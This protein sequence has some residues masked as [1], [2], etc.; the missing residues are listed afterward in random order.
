MRS[1]GFWDETRGYWGWKRLLLPDP[2]CLL[3]LPFDF[4][5]P[6]TL[7]KTYVHLLCSVTRICAPLA[8]SCLGQLVLT[9]PATGC[10]EWLCSYLEHVPVPSGPALVFTS[11]TRMVLKIYNPLGLTDTQ[12]LGVANCFCE[13]FQGSSMIRT[14]LKEPFLPLFSSLKELDSC[15]RNLL[16]VFSIFQKTHQAGKWPWDPAFL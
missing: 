14:D 2:L 9:V 6:F 5:Q 12:T 8:P 16:L 3:G 11:F 13:G 15:L 10:D 7:C 4:W 1:K